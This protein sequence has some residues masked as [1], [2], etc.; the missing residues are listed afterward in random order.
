M[1]QYPES[2]REA[3]KHINEGLAFFKQAKQEVQELKDEY[4]KFNRKLP[5]KEIAKILNCTPEHVSWLKRKGRLKS[6]NMNDVLTYS[7]TH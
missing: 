3:E 2:I 1:P 5:R 4:R 7:K 6:Y